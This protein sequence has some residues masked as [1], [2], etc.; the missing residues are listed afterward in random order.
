MGT[1]LRWQHLGAN[2]VATANA[3][4]TWTNNTN[5]DISIR[6][7]DWDGYTQEDATDAHCG[8]KAQL[9]KDD[10]IQT[11]NTRTGWSPEV[12]AH[13]SGPT[14]ESPKQVGQVRRSNAYPRGAVLLRPNETLN[15]HTLALT[16]ADAGE[17][18]ADIGYEFL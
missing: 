4:A 16:A 3:A 10:S 2:F 14:A 12:Y 18:G 11:G 15:L 8:M 6:T 5:Q 1:E 7:V 13:A 9:S 17:I